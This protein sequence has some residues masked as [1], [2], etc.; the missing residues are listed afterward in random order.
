[1]KQSEFTKITIVWLKNSK[2][3]SN[4][5]LW[6]I[7]KRWLSKGLRNIYS[8]QRCIYHSATT[9]LMY[10]II[11]DNRTRVI[12][13]PWA[14][15]EWYR[16]SYPDIAAAQHH[17][18]WSSRICNETLL[19]SE[20][21]HLYYWEFLH[22]DQTVDSN[23]MVVLMQLNDTRQRILFTLWQVLAFLSLLLFNTIIL[24]MK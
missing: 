3:Q 19:S 13:G 4:N 18:R 6:V 12:S 23:A 16:K 2:F 5:H 1:M 17:N 15:V 14:T 7:Y 9:L 20:L 22:H 11:N 8:A 10:Y 21:Q 24:S